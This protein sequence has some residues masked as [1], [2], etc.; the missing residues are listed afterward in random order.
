[1][2]SS[3]SHHL[4]K[5]SSPNTIILKVRLPY[6]NPG[7][8]IQSTAWRMPGKPLQ[9]WLSQWMRPLC[10]LLTLVHDD[11]LSAAVGT[12]P[13]TLRLELE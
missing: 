11:A 13:V 10:P 12:G 8:I 4:P 1:M 9:P 3:H 2:T 5:D 7:E 6:A